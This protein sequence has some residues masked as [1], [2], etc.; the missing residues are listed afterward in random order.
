[1]AEFFEA[2]RIVGVLRFMNPHLMT[3]SGHFLYETGSIFYEF[4]VIGQF[5]TMPDQQESF[6]PHG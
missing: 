3:Y 6:L 5:T 2:S 4:L 1:M